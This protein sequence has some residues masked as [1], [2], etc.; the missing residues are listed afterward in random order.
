MT[1]ESCRRARSST[2]ARYLRFQVPATVA[3][4]VAL[5]AAV[6]YGFVDAATAGVVLLLWVAKDLALYPLL[7]RAYERGGQGYPSRLVGRSATARQDLAPRGYVLVAG[8][9]WRAEAVGED[10]PIRAGE[11]VVVTGAVGTRLLVCRAQGADME[12][13]T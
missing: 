4:A 6:H 13:S 1:N 12:R 8:E 3:V 5:A 7:R 9:L 11:N 2:F 10:R